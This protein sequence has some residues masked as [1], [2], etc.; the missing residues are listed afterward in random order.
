MKRLTLFTLILLWTLFAGC[1]FLSPSSTDKVSFNVPEKQLE[2]QSQV[3]LSTY[4]NKPYGFSLQFPSDRTFEENVYGSTVMLFTPQATGDKLRENV[5]IIVQELPQ[6][7]TLDEYATLTISE[8]EQMIPEFK[9][10]ST[11]SVILADNYPAYTIMYQGKQGQ[12][13]LQRQQVFGIIDKQVYIIT[14]TATT[15]TFSS[16]MDEVHTIISSLSF[17]R[18]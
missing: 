17:A 2:E 12:F 9:I 8:L 6:S 4:Q 3:V 16:F 13:D 11:G 5:G 7:Y 10:V 14:Y 1:T 18:K 15:D